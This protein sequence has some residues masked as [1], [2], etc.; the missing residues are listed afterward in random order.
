MSIFN[1]GN[2]YIFKIKGEDNT[3]TF[4]KAK[5][6]FSSEYTSEAYFIILSFKENAQSRDNYDLRKIREIDLD[7]IQ[8]FNNIQYNDFKNDFKKTFFFSVI[9]E[10]FNVINNGTLISNSSSIFTGENLTLKIIKSKI[11]PIDEW[12]ESDIRG[13]NNNILSNA[14]IPADVTAYTR[15]FLGGK[16]RRNKR[17]K[18]FVKKS[19]KYVK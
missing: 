15:K 11:L 18:R 6:L 2:T 14:Q 1:L 19:K 12:K 13:E 4:F 3:P 17:R 9:V 7:R 8:P 16:S 10:Q 5:C